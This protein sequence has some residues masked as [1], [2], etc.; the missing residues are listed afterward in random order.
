LLPQILPMV[1]SD[2]VTLYRRHF[3]KAGG[4]VHTEARVEEVARNGAGLDVRFTQAGEAKSVPAQV[5]L[6]AT[7]RVPY[8]EGLG[9]EDAGVE[10]DRGRVVVDDHL[11]TAADGVWAI[12]DVIGGIMLAHVASYE[13]VCAVENICGASRAPDYH[14]VPNCIYT[15]PEIANVGLG[16]REARE[17]GLEVRVGRFPLSASGRALTLGQAEGAVKVVAAAADGTVLGV[18]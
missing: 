17:R 10:L 3:E 11:R 16:E 4:F 9:L 6:L 5:V 2:V 8:T 1:E 7:G 18:P 13:G 14:A 12:G 15:D